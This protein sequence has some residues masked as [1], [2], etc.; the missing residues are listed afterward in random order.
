MTSVADFKSI[1]VGIAEEGSDHASSALAYGLSFAQAAQA[2]ITVQAAALKVSVP[3]SAVSHFASELAG[4][5]NRRVREAA[6]ATVERARGTADAAGLTC[7]VETLQLPFAELLDAF[8]NQARV[9]DVSVLETTAEQ[10][11][12]A[13]DVLENVV[14]RSGRPVLAVPPG[15]TLFRAERI[16]IAW[17]G[18]ERVA[19]AVAFALPLLKAAKE[20]EILCIKGEKDLTHAV[21]GAELAP[22][23]VRHGVSVS[24]NDVSVRDGDAVETLRGQ[25]GIF[26]A[27][28]VV[29]GAF[30]HSRLQ[31]W[32]LGGFTRALIERSSVPLFLAH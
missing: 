32:F 30:V 7:S 26:R 17:D 3:R 21:P 22:N 1:L 5:E 14:T 28:M 4:A 8:V 16:A 6:A 13:R 18:S 27:D 2:H 25:M 20:V 11:E 12:M 24:V 9:H 19:R 23:L 31:Q 15:I 10:M 29:M